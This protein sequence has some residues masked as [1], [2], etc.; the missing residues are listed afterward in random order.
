LRIGINFKMMTTRGVRR[1]EISNSG[2]QDQ[3]Q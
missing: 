3:F 2:R 1:E